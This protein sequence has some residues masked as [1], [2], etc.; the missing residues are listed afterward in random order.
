M[1]PLVVRLSCACLLATQPNGVYPQTKRDSPDSQ[2]APSTLERKKQ[3]LS[4]LQEL[5]YLRQINKK[6][7]ET[8]M[9]KERELDTLKIDAELLEQATQARI[10]EKTAALVEEVYSA[11]RERDEAI[12]ARLRLANEERDEAL[13]RVQQLQMVLRQVEDINPEEGDTTIQELLGRLDDAECGTAI[14]Q[15]GELILEQIKRSRERRAQI[16]DEEMGAVIQE[17]DAARAQCKHL[18]KELH[19]LKESKQICSDIVAAQRTLDPASKT[20]LPFL[21]H[22]QDKV[23]EDYK[24]LEEELQ[25]LHVY[26]SLHQSLSQEENLKEHF[27][28][29]MDLFDEAL[30]NRQ[31][32]LSIIQKQNQELGQQLREVKAENRELQESLSKSSSAQQEMEEKVRKLERLVEVLRK[33]VGTGSVRTVI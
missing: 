11:Q 20:S 13:L 19:R 9:S 6:L 23:I 33:K 4:L 10:A 25:N 14:R 8:L 16:T 27:S 12:M 28:Q 5:D 17:R 32:L 18:E 22:D 26:Y 21:L 3:D 29:A 7:Q 15:N 31:K 1:F 24:R 2:A 30:R